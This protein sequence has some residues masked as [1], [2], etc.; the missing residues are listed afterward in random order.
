[1]HLLS[2]FSSFFSSEELI[3]PEKKGIEKRHG[4]IF[5]SDVCHVVSDLHM[6]LDD[7][8]EGGL[9]GNSIGTTKRGNKPSEVCYTYICIGDIFSRELFDRKI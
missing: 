1:M 6:R 4:R 7:L 9:C 3:D 5:I 2:F 8:E